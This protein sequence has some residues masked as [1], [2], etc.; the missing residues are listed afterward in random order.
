MAAELNESLNTKS[1]RQKDSLRDKD[2]SEIE[3][4][5][6]FDDLVDV[7]GLGGG[8]GSLFASKKERRH[9]SVYYILKIILFFSVMCIRRR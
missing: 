5:D 6:D 7:D 1:D 8:D 2:G 4:D 9:S 3:F